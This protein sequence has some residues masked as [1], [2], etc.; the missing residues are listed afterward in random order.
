MEELRKQIETALGGVEEIVRNNAIVSVTESSPELSTAKEEDE[1]V[2]YVSIKIKKKEE[3]VEHHNG[4]T[5]SKGHNGRQ[6]KYSQHGPGG[7]QGEKGPPIQG[8]EII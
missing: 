4:T 5:A 8:K 1:V 3:K 2:V 7:G 6:E